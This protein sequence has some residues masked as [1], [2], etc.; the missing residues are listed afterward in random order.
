MSQQKNN[1]KNIIIFSTL[2]LVIIITVGIIT[3]A[4]NSQEEEKPTDQTETSNE[5]NMQT[6]GSSQTELKLE[7]E[8][9]LNQ[10]GEENQ[11][12]TS[13]YR[14]GEFTASGTYS[15]PDGTDEIDVSVTL[16]NGVIE[17]VSV[18]TN[19]K[20][21]TGARHQ[22]LFAEGIAGEVEGERIDEVEV[23][24]VNGSSLTGA[25]FNQA[26]GRIRQEARI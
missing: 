17:S 25:G 2:A 23:G 6:G 9:N 11:G 10:E 21:T 7:V 14:D 18:E 22:Q 16:R 1:S 26:I 12:E 4:F 15:S 3:V 20:S 19:P 24:R 5:E 8:N 13:S